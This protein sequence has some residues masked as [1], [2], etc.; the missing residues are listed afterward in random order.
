MCRTR[1]EEDEVKTS[2]LESWNRHRSSFRW[3]KNNNNKKPTDRKRKRIDH[4]NSMQ[5]HH[6]STTRN[7]KGDLVAMQEAVWAIYFHKHS[8][9][10]NLLATSAKN[11][12]ARTRNQA[13]G[14]LDSYKHANNLPVAVCD[15]IK[16]IFKD[17][18]NAQLLCKC[19]DGYVQNA[20]E[21][22]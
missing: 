22:E 11:S 16:P 20:N 21:S 7:N 12:G 8:Q 13:K 14:A 4:I 6:G 3:G 15:E 1:T 9:T 2:K 10:E 5:E 19:L 18:A 17:L